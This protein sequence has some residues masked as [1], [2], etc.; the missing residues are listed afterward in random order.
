MDQSDKV[1]TRQGID[2]KVQR[3]PS[4]LPLK[5]NREQAVIGSSDHSLG[6]GRGHE[7]EVTR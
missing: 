4:Q 5:L 7:I 2:L 1:P 3:L 6:N